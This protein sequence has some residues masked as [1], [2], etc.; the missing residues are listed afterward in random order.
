MIIIHFFL[1]VRVKSSF[2]A[3]FITINREEIGKKAK[4]KKAEFQRLYRPK[5]DIFYL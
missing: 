1:N 4:K 3:H 5:T 2:A